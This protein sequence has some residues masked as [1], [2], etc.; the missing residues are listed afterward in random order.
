MSE[1]S[2]F[3]LG[4]IPDILT[5][6]DPLGKAR[7]GSTYNLP[8]GKLQSF[9]NHPFKIYEGERFT[10]MMES[11]KANGVIIPIIVRPLDGGTYEILS[12]H[13]RVGA[14]KAAGLE[15]IPA[16]VREGL[17]DDEALLIVTE[18]NLIQRSF[19]DL[20]HSERAVALAARHDAIKRQGKRTDLIKEIEN[21]VNASNIADSETC[22]QV[23]HKLKSMDKTGQDYGISKNTVARYLRINKLIQPHKKRIDDGGISLL[24]GVALSYL[25]EKEQQIVDDVLRENEYRVD[26]KKAELLRSVSGNKGL[27]R[28]NADRILSGAGCKKKNASQ[29]TNTFKISSKIMSKYFNPGDKPDEIENIINKALELYY[30]QNQ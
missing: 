22:S 26:M 2:G 10:D 16:I 25:S 9:K 23:G 20:S 18:T 21:M 28:D 24:A 3:Q 6:T 12:G 14:A 30:S 17:S 11:I 7:S 5:A 1:K 13:N 27:D 29:R 4:K 8:L 15:V 19:A